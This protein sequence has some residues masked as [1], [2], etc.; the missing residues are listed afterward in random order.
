MYGPV[1]DVLGFMAPSS[2]SSAEHT[3]AAMVYPWNDGWADFQNQPGLR[4]HRRLEDLGFL[5][6]AGVHAVRDA[7]GDEVTALQLIV[8]VVARGWKWLPRQVMGDTGSDG[9]YRAIYTN[10]VEKLESMAG[11]NM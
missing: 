8:D 7:C 2:S 11:T 6:V 9:V 5:T 3:R 1:Y 10:F 4:K